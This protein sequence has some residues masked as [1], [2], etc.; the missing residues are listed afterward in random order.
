ML[1]N[2]ELVTVET[3]SWNRTELHQ[4]KCTLCNYLGSIGDEFHYLLECKEFSEQRKKHLDHQNI[5]TPNFMLFKSVMN[6]MVA[7]VCH[8]ITI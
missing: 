2:F 5:R 3:G 4:R 6:I 1:V 8:Q 7:Y